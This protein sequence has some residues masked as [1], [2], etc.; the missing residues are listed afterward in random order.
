MLMACT[1]YFKRKKDLIDEIPIFFR[2]ST[3]TDGSEICIDFLFREHYFVLKQ[4]SCFEKAEFIEVTAKNKEKPTEIND[5]ADAI[6][7][8]MFL[9][10]KFGCFVYVWNEELD[11]STKKR[12][13]HYR[14]FLNGRSC[15]QNVQPQITVQTIITKAPEIIAK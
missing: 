9:S 12:I 1:I 10:K 15:T 8:G 11:F 6:A 5:N 3:S 13:P 14:Y 7:L 2:K 4:G